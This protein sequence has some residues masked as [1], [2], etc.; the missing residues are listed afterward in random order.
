MIKLEET[1]NMNKKNKRNRFLN[2]K[3]ILAFYLPVTIL[4]LAVIVPLIISPEYLAR[5]LS[6]QIASQTNSQVQIKSAH[7]SWLNGI[8]IDKLILKKPNAKSII[9]INEIRMPINPFNLIITRQLSYIH[10]KGLKIDISESD[11]FTLPIMQNGNTEFQPFILP[12]KRLQIENLSVSIKFKDRTETIYAFPW[13]EIITEKD[14]QNIQWYGHCQISFLSS[15]STQTQNAGKL[16]VNGN[17]KMSELADQKIFAGTMKLNWQHLSLNA[18]HIHKISQLN[19][20]NLTGISN[21]ALTLTIFPDFNLKWTLKTDFS[22]L[23]IRKIDGSSTKFTKLAIASTGRYDP[24]AGNIDMSH[25]NIE[26]P[27]VKLNSKFNLDFENAVLAES[28]LH[29][30][31]QFDTKLAE[32]LFTESKNKAKF[33]GQCTFGIDCKITGQTYTLQASLNAN[34]AEFHINDVITKTSGTPANLSVSLQADKS[35]WP[36]M[37]VKQFKINFAN[38]ILD[39]FARLPRIYA[40][41]DFNSWITRAKNLGQMEFNIK[42]D[43]IRTLARQ[44]PSLEAFL[45]KFSL[46]GTT[47]INI[48]YTGQNNIASTEFK[49][50]MPKGSTFSIQD[51][52]VKP[53]NKNLTVAIKTY[54]PWKSEYGELSFLLDASCGK[55]NINTYNRP[56]KLIWSFRKKQANTE[57]ILIDIIS[58]MGLQIE[59]IENIIKCSPIL[60][61]RNLKGKFAGTVRLDFANAYQFIINDRNWDI[62]RC[63]TFAKID[64]TQA[65]LNIP[66]Q[67]K[68]RVGQLLQLIL[69]YKFNK[70]YSRHKLA[71]YIHSDGMTNEIQISKWRD[72]GIHYNGQFALNINKITQTI[73]P[74]IK[75]KKR[76]GKEVKLDGKFSCNFNWTKSPELSTLHWNINATNTNIAIKDK[77][78]KT[79]SIPATITGGLKLKLDKQNKAQTYIFAPMQIKLG[80]NLIRLKKGSLNL[81][82]IP[83]DKWLKLVG[84]EPWVAFRKSPVKSLDAKL[85]GKLQADEQLKII[86]P[87]LANLCHKYNIDGYGQ[88]D[89]DLL[90]QNSQLNVHL[91]GNLEKLKIHAGK[92]LVKS[93]EVPGKLDIDL[94]IWPDSQNTHSWLCSIDK[95][96]FSLEPLQ[97][98]LTGHCKLNWSAHNRLNISEATVETNLYPLNLKEFSKLSPILKQTSANGYL[99]SKIDLRYNNNTT[100]AGLSFIRFDNIKANVEGYPFAID[101]RIEFSD[102]YLSCDDLNFLAGSTSLKTNLQCFAKNNGG[103]IGYSDFD[104]PHIDVDELKTI[105][106]KLSDM[107]SENKGKNSKNN[108]DNP[109][110]KPVS[111]QPDKSYQKQIKLMKHCAPLFA[112]AIKSSLLINFNSRTFRYTDYSQHVTHDIK[113]LICKAFVTRENKATLNFWGRVSDGMIK[114]NISANL[115]QA[116]PTITLVSQLY[117][118]KMNP[119]LQPLVENFFPGLK[120]TGR[121]SIKENYTFKMFRTST[122]PNNPVGSGEMTFIDGYMIGRAAPEWV[123]KIFPQLNFAKYKFSRMRN[124]FYK[125]ADGRV[126]NNMIYRGYPWNIYIEGDSYPDGRV[127]YEVG[128]DL[129]ARFESQ[130]WSSVGQGRV[131]IFTTEGLIKNGKFVR[132]KI[133]YVPPYKVIYQVFIKNNILTG[134]Y[135]ML[136][137]KIT[138]HKKSKK[139][140]NEFFPLD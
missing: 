16:A 62:N 31:G 60:Q 84:A 34:N 114:G 96:I 101:G 23:N 63:R 106:C 2:L 100:K 51:F 98:K 44:I 119:S 4:L 40:D 128:V 20:T 47:Q 76:L 78:I 109:A 73:A 122:A 38:L 55:L 42:S 112:W 83:E 140:E 94:F 39:G 91:T 49:I 8:N 86:S 32:M 136:K 52:Y 10:I 116:N 68:K 65:S 115:S 85:T 113:N 37:T 93:S 105:I 7:F 137:Q 88:F 127:K 54:W 21:G 79:S 61:K 92:Y 22:A 28:N 99:S 43:N 35:N 46:S 107:S 134:A 90:M 67:F 12:I 69:D 64:V 13:L 123:T 71:T 77:I 26:S 45:H 29:I 125:T 124:W 87:Q 36:W 50:Q 5:T 59:H 33:S 14:N 97:T 126:H 120:I 66:E 75:L 25:L 72:N 9:K 110:S 121:I 132:E 95:M 58:D 11:K 24:I 133:R 57:S 111:S 103:L 30:S 3:I 1:D 19:L 41:D 17:L 82:N 102:K 18:L 80:K 70:K 6:R 48:D 135:R 108:S 56:T 27:S 104:S 117:N 130:Y 15:S 118:L 81:N 129:L 89:I 131:P 139:N 138:N 53:K 74:F